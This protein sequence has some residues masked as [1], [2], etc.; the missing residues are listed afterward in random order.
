MEALEVRLQKGIEDF[1]C[2]KGLFPWQTLYCS[3]PIFLKISFITKSQ[4]FE[5][6]DYLDFKNLADKSGIQVCPDGFTVIIR[7]ITLKYFLGKI[8]TDNEVSS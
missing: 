4:C 1:L 3:D 2:T 7:G 6:L 8:E 5:F